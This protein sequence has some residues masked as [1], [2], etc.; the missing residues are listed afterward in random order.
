MSEKE[1][2]RRL[3]AVVTVA[4]PHPVEVLLQ[5]FVLGELSLHLKRPP[6]F[7]DF[8]RDR[9]LCPVGIQMTCQLLCDR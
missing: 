3:D 6:Q 1:L 2:A 8:P 9:D 4:K 5:D 7:P